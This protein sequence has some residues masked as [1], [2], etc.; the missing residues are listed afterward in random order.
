MGVYYP[1]VNFYFKLSF[2]GIS[3]ALDYAFQEVSGLNSEMGYEEIQEGGENRF[4]YKVPSGAKYNNLVV[5]RGLVTFN[6]QLAQWCNDTVLSDLSAKV[7]PKNITVM[8]M[9]A[10]GKALMTWSFVNAWP[11]KW[12][13]SDLESSKGEIS[14]ESIE[15]AYNYYKFVT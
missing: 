2:T 4:K 9:D 5:K 6:S 12:S 8:L 15:F 11:V 7:E 10:N 14:I 3:S 1:P 13:V